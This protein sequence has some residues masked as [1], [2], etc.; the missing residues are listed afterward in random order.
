MMY[1]NWFLTNSSQVGTVWAAHKSDDTDPNFHKTLW[2]TKSDGVSSDNFDYFS[3]LDNNTATDGLAFRMSAPSPTGLVVNEYF[4]F[5]S[6]SYTAD[7]PTFVLPTT[8]NCTDAGFAAD[9]YEAHALLHARG[10][11]H[12]PLT[13]VFIASMD[14]HAPR[15]QIQGM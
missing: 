14:R 6:A 4:G 3:F 13:E 15:P 2:T 9:A 8:P 7:D 12:Y 10:L 5:S 11:G 1:P